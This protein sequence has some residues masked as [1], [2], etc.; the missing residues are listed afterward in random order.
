MYFYSSKILKTWHLLLAENCELL[1]YYS[2][3]SK[4]SEFFQIQFKC[5]YI[6]HLK[7]QAG[8]NA[9]Q[10]EIAKTTQWNTKAVRTTEDN[11]QTELNKN[12]FW[13]GI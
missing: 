6:A 1:Y 10:S 3:L 8:L 2:Y 9:E 13:E 12:G 4:R 5:I 11:P 7:Q